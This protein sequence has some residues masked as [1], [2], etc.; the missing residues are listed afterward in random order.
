LGSLAE[1]VIGTQAERRGWLDN[2]QLNALNTALGGG[3]A[4]LL[5]RAL[6]VRP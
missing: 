4:C 1:S 5:A 2:D 6:D 3:A